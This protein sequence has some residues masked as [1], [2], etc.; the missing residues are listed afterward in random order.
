VLT[1]TVDHAQEF[2]EIASDF[3]NP[4]NLDVLRLSKLLAGDVTEARN[5]NSEDATGLHRVGGL[6]RSVAI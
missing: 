1:P 5:G 2:I 3:A 4:L 6:V